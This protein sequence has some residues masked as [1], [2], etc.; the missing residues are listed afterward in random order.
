[1]VVAQF[2]CIDF[3]TCYNYLVVLVMQCIMNYLVTLSK[4]KQAF[5]ILLT[6]W[7]AMTRLACVWKGDYLMTMTRC[8]YVS[9]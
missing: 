4:Y 7:I 3:D 8:N 9:I 5:D 1:M 6:K 2:G